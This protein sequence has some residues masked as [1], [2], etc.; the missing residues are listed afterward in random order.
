MLG[1]IFQFSQVLGVPIEEQRAV[2]RFRRPRRNPMDQERYRVY[3][4]PNRWDV[5]YPG[6]QR[7]DERMKGW[8][9]EMSTATP[10]RD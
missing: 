7:H 6:F 8:R 10:R 5:G 4:K 2:A 3:A 9:I 1:L